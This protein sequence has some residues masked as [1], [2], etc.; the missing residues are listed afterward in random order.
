[1]NATCGYL[2][3]MRNSVLSVAMLAMVLLGCGTPRTVSD[4]VPEAKET[5]APVVTL[6]MDGDFTA[7]ER[8]DAF[9]AAEV[10]RKQTQGLARIELVYDVDFND[11]MGLGQL[12]AEEANIVVRR[13]SEDPIVQ[14]ADEEEGCDSC[15]LGW[16]NA[17]GI[18]GPGHQPIHGAFVV[19]RLSVSREMRVQ[20]MIHEFGHVLGVPHVAAIQGLMYPYAMPGR[21]SCLKQPDLVAFC[22]V[23]ECAD[24]HMLPCE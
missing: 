3:S 21:T 15:V 12:F 7:E 9:K 6:H 24:V 2:V 1:M 23:N 4:V 14:A 19:D 5:S 22:S 13:D 20:V 11:L 17:G 8:A 10:W 18:H 16:M